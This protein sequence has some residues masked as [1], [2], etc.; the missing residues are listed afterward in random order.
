[1]LQV[2]EYLLI[3]LQKNPRYNEALFRRRFR[4][5]RSLYLCIIDVVKMHEP[6]FGQ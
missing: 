3:I 6:Y 1:M 4:M 5:S 2:I